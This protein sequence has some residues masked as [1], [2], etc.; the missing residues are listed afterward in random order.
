MRPAGDVD[1]TTKQNWPDVATREGSAVAPLDASFAPVV[2]WTMNETSPGMG[3]GVS[4]MLPCVVLQPV[5]RTH[6]L[7][8]WQSWGPP[9]GL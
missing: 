4:L 7:I 8:A 5:F 6:P 2:G 3:T 9:G 1:K